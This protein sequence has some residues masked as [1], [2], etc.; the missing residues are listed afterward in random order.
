MAR[1]PSRSVGEA[2]VHREEEDY[3]GH[4]RAVTDLSPPLGREGSLRAGR[5]LPGN[6]RVMCRDFRVNS[7]WWNPGE[8]RERVR[9]PADKAREGGIPSVFRPKRN[10]EHS[11]A[12]W[13]SR[14]GSPAEHR[15]GF[16]TGC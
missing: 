5:S 6:I 15:V 13:F 4:A 9:R 2:D 8:R 1:P 14:D 16:T 7:L 10:A 12:E 3:R 11:E